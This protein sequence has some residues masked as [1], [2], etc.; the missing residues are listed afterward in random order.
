MTSESSYSSQLQGKTLFEL[1]SF[2][3]FGFAIIFTISLF[4]IFPAYINGDAYW[5]LYL[6]Q[7]VI[8]GVD[9]YVDFLEINP[10]LIV[11]LGIPPAWIGKISGFSIEQIFKVYIFALILISMW[12]SAKIMSAI[13]LPSAATIFLGLAFALLIMPG[14]GFGQREHIMLVLSAPYIF[15]VIARSQNVH[16]P[17]WLIVL[18]TILGSIGFCIKPY[19]VLIPAFLELYLLTILGFMTFRRIEPYIMGFLGLSYLASIFLFTPEYLGDF[20]RYTNAIYTAGYGISFSEMLL[21]SWPMLIPMSFGLM[22]YLYIREDIQRADNGYV[23]LALAMLAA[24]TGFFLQF[25]GWPNHSY[26]NRALLFILIVGLLSLAY[27]FQWHN[28][29]VRLVAIITMIPIILSTIMPI[30]FLRYQANGTEKLFTYDIKKI[31]NVDTI[32]LMSSDL[33]DAFPLINNTKL[34]W[35]SRFA[36]QWLTPGVQQKI[37][38]GENSPLLVEIKDFAHRAV[39]ED[40]ARYKPQLVIVHSSENKRRYNAGRYDYIEDFSTNAQFAE[41]W[42]NYTL[43]KEYKNWNM[44]ERINN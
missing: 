1:N 17:Y 16:L 3:V 6:S 30:L 42:T 21:I 2:L 35:G 44:F 37:A 29:E 31:Q 20:L 7:Q 26:P 11:W 25:K 38:S 9:P 23:V 24:F 41:E 8:D 14:V 39:A 33:H 18:S 10:P 36:S 19:F 32:F 4:M 40:L 27:R 5:L 13:K 43:K 28:R 12:L 34:K 22:I 15:V